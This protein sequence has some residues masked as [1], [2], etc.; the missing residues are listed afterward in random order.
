MFRL[1]I[2]TMVSFYVFFMLLFTQKTAYEKRISDWSSDVCSSD[3][4]YSY[5]NPDD[6]LL[7]LDVLAYYTD[8]KA[9]ELRLDDLGA[10]PEGELLK[11]DEI[12]RASGRDR[13]RQYV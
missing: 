9:D 3:L 13:V 11:R 1:N 5:S 4:A 12:G 2:T 7:D 10:G 6:N 8:M